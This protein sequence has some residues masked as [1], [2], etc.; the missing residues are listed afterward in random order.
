MTKNS[1]KFYKHIIKLVVDLNEYENNPNT[2]NDKNV[3]EIANSIKEFG[4]TNPVLIDESNMV[5][6]GHGRLKAAN[7]LGLEEVPCIV[8]S[9]LT[10]AQKR[11]YVIA[12]NALAEGSAWD[13]ELLSQEVDFLRD[14]DYDIDL[15]GLDNIDID[16]D[17][18]A[19]GGVN[20]G[21]NDNGHSDNVNESDTVLVIGEYRIPIPRQNYLDWQED[22]RGKV[23]FEKKAI[24]DEIIKRLSLCLN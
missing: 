3:S 16:L 6:A 18:Y 17:G 5:I 20:D 2:H 14:L 13:E 12:D 24:T 8:L 15:L 22:I 9:G 23:G 11:A 19:P 4:F 10:D 21:H 7:K 1:T